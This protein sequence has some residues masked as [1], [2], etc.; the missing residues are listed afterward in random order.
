M[1]GGVGMV[2]SRH[3]RRRGLLLLEL[4]IALAVFVAITTVL[5]SSVRRSLG[6]IEFARD[7]LRAEDFAASVIAMLD[8]SIE[9][10]EVLNGPLPEWSALDGYFG[11]GLG[12]SSAMGFRDP[13]EAWEIEID[14]APAGIAGFTSVTVTVRR[15]DRPGVVAQREALI[16]FERQVSQRGLP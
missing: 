9:S 7:R 15:N 10:P 1:T 12:S 5:F 8:S 3:S 11:A 6:S 14:T 13:S 16:D 2:E 4:V